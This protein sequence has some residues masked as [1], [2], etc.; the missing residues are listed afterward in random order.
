VK[1][2][3]SQFGPAWAGWSREYPHYPLFSQ[4]STDILRRGTKE[5]SGPVQKF[6][7]TMDPGPTQSTDRIQAGIDGLSER[8][9][10]CLTLAPGRHLSGPLR[11]AA[12]VELH[13]SAG[14]ELHFLPDYA[15]YAGNT[16]SV[17]AEQSDRAM[18]LARHAHR[19]GISGAGKIVAGGT[20]GFSRGPDG[21][22]G[23][24][25]PAPRRPRVLVVEA[26]DDFFLREATLVDSPMWTV[27]L[28]GCRRARLDGLTI[29]NNRALPNTDGVVAD[30]GEDIE[31][32]DCD[33][34]TADDGIVL[35]TSTPAPLC[36]V[37]VTGCRVSSQSCALKIGTETHGDIR[38]VVFARCQVVD[39]N[40]ALGIFSR[41][42]GE[43]SDIVF[44]DIAVDCHETPDGFWGS[45][46]AFTL[47]RLTR[48]AG[49]PAG[50]V[51]R[52]LVESITGRAE[53]AIC[54]WDEGGGVS[55]LTLSR[56][57]LSQGQGALGTG[58]QID[59]RP[60]PADLTPGNGRANAWTRDAR[61]QV[62][63]L[64][65][66]PSGLP[67]LYARRIRPVLRDIALHRPDPLPMGWSVEPFTA[68]D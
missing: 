1:Y 12:G 67:G 63:G 14:A 27:H 18:I 55:D 29:R 9:G 51:R 48:R 38:D 8:G 44:S 43:I 45:G 35:K 25:I 2:L 6:Q 33:I 65:P 7:L 32:T 23:V 68:Q 54:L 50:A 46:E 36:G 49:R 28:I 26:S 47:T 11:L 17:T 24:L 16:S 41:D 66:Y 61:G 53:G 40:R 57:A 56:I 3:H 4:I 21:D 10:G 64:T 13:L 42:G 5:G 15:T 39:S 20:Q 60:T 30:G 37:R 52:V 31:I 34:E 58:A 22:M 59:L 19:A 62:V